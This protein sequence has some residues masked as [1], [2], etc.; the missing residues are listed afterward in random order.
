MLW[1]PKLTVPDSSNYIFTHVN[2]YHYSPP[3]GFCFDLLCKNDPIKDDEDLEDYNLVA[4]AQEL[5]LY[6]KSQSVHFRS[7]HLMH[8]LGEDFH[9]AN[10]RMWFKNIDKL[11][12]FINARPEFGVKLIYSTPSKYIKQIQSE[13]N[14]YPIKTDDFF[15]YADYQH[16][17]WTGYFTSRPAVKG[18]VR[19][20]G[21]WLQATRKLVSEAKMRGDSSTILSEAK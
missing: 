20:F 2:Y 21:R 9:Y 6:F 7:S 19:D 15:P 1:K 5:V 12:K 3:P 8:T 4:K 17:Y 16:A 18:F 13:S 10:A 11:I 14:K